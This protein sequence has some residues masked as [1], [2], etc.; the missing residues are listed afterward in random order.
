MTHTNPKASVIITTFQR[1]ERLNKA[2]DSVLG[3]E[4]GNVE[5]IVVDDNG[6]GTTAQIQTEASLKPYYANPNF[7]YLKMEKNGGACQARNAGAAAASGQYLFFLDDDDVFLPGKVA[8]Q[9]YTLLNNPQSDGCLTAF[10]R[11]REDGSEIAAESNFPAVGTFQEFAI[12]GNFF[13]PMICITKSAFDSVGGFK[14]ISRFQDRYF[15]LHCLAQ[16]LRFQTLRE[17]SYTMFEHTSGRITHQSLAKTMASLD[18]ICKIVSTK[19]SGFTTKQ[20]RAFI[21]NDAKM[22]ATAYYV[23]PVYSERLK[24][25]AYWLKAFAIRKKRSYLKSLIKSF[26]P[27]F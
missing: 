6:I 15:M 5:I 14:E 8:L 19:K 7:C 4:Y 22:R 16:G 24:G 25:V 13:T 23:S 10:I 20:W 11:L 26:V 1:S 12:K 2:I 27:R 3:Q 18:Q 21:E 9:I 17:V